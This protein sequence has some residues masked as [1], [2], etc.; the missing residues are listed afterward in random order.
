MRDRQ[1]DGQTPGRCYTL[2]S[3]LADAVDL[4]HGLAV[5]ADEL[6]VAG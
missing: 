2:S 6:E 3:Y 5:L 1:T 4:L